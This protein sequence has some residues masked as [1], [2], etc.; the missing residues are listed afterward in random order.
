[1]IAHQY[2]LMTVYQSLLTL[3]GTGIG[4]YSVHWYLC[5]LFFEGQT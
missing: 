5:N 1:M 2:G 3:V 4:M